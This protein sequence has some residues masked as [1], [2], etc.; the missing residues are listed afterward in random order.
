MQK[1]KISSDV[2]YDNFFKS[3]LKGFEY[4]NPSVALKLEL[5]NPAPF[6]MY[7]DLIRVELRTQ[8]LNHHETDLSIL[9]QTLRTCH[10]PERFRTVFSFICFIY[11]S[12][13]CPTTSSRG[14][15]LTVVLA[16]VTSSSVTVL[17]L[18]CEDRILI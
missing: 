5:N 17:T 9:L 8:H 11:D 15:G 7:K 1:N 4:D 14:Q 13:K 3:D 2:N 6:S 12:I 10:S 16:L 18:C